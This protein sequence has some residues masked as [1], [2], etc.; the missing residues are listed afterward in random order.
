MGTCV[1]QTCHVKAISKRNWRN[2]NEPRNR[3]VSTPEFNPVLPLRALGK[4]RKTQS[5]SPC[6]SSWGNLRIFFK[7]PIKTGFLASGAKLGMKTVKWWNEDRLDSHEMSDFIYQIWAGRAV[8][9]LFLAASHM[10]WKL[11]RL[12]KQLRA[13]NLQ[14]THFWS[15]WE[16]LKGILSL[17]HYWV[18]KNFSSVCAVPAHRWWSFFLRL[19][20]PCSNPGSGKPINIQENEP[21]RI[22]QSEIQSVV[23][24]DN[25]GNIILV[26]LLNNVDGALANHI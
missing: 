9:K 8:L 26:T 3:G 13:Q 21:K 25:M 4:P 22:A 11:P 15:F 14:L 17:D 5:F 6:P 20:K 24:V 23:H 7:W 2:N 18:P 1:L 10:W 16:D 12:A 19:T